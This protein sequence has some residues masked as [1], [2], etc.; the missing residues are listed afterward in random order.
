MP[1]KEKTKNT[2]AA[3]S[4]SPLAD[5]AAG[6][7]KNDAALDPQA[8]T[9]P[10]DLKTLATAVLRTNDHGTYTIPA[11]N[12]YPHQWLWDSCFIAIGLRH[13][14]PMRACQELR[15]LVRGQWANGMLPNMIFSD[16]SEYNHDRNYWRSWINPN[17][18][19][20]VATSGITQ[21]PMFAEAVWQVGQ[22]LPP[23]ERRTWFREMFPVIVDYHSW[24]YDERD[25]HDE[26]L[27]LLVHPWETGL[28]NTPPWMAE[29]HEHNMPAWIKLVKTLRLDNIIGSLRRDHHYIPP[30]Q[31]LSTIEILSL[32]D[33]QRRLR[34][35]RY[36]TYSIIKRGLFSIEDLTFNSILLRAN[37]RLRQIADYLRRQIPDD[38]EANMALTP[39]A[40]EKLWD[41]QTKQYY[42]R[43]FSTH[44]LLLQPSIAALMPLY[45]GVISPERAAQLV[46]GL[47]N[48]K[49]FGAVF[50]VPSVPLDSPY[51][52]PQLYWQGPSWVNTNWLIIDGLKRYGFDDHAAALIE[53]TLDMVGRSGFAEYFDPVTGEPLGARD[54]SWTAALTIDL[55]KQSKG[56]KAD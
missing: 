44:R 1:S 32:F 5:R 33:A 2:D 34:R 8:V 12:L 30:G 9:K 47:E 26:G 14:D 43:D 54:F 27:I 49:K 46:R 55:L 45:A 15:S 35:K 51:F 53:T 4:G 31:R 41:E 25:P 3:K 10:A 56:R 6:T 29:L 16:A 13:L 19:E 52:N 17:A 7:K 40:L 38:L 11:A 22:V 24:L 21:P 39:A 50:P 20:G 28:D 48:D 42:S 18:P 37:E 23:T 36:D